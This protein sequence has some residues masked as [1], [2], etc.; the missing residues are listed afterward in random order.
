MENSSNRSKLMSPAVVGVR[1]R[2]QLGW[3]L[4]RAGRSDGFINQVVSHLA[5]PIDLHRD[6]QLLARYGWC[7][8]QLGDGPP[9]DRSPRS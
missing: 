7:P 5:D 1:S 9:R 2:K 4:Q 3:V 6:Q 8:F